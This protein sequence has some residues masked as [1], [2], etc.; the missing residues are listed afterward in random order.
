MDADLQDDPAVNKKFGKENERS[1]TILLLA[2][3]KTVKTQFLKQS[4]ET[5]QFVTSLVSGINCTISIA[6]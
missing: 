1:A 2:G 6:G 4:I 3:S 5:V